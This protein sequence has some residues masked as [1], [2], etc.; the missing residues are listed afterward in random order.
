M[1]EEIVNCVLK[2]L[3][4]KCVP[5]ASVHDICA[6]VC[7]SENNSINHYSPLA[8][9]GDTILQEG[10]LIKIDIRA[11]IDGFIAVVG[12]TVVVGASKTNKVK[13]RKAD[14]IMA[15]HNASEAALC[16]VKPSN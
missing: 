13:E 3:V 7:A 11:H 16:L 8:S 6:E 4:A 2:L 12:H 10:D 1:A 14:V 5:L 15:A 9:E